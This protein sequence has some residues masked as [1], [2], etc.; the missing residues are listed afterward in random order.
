MKLSLYQGDITDEHVDAIVNAANERL[1]H[2]GGVAA[3]IVQKGGR[4]IQEESTRKIKQHGPLKVGEAAF[5]NEILQRRVNEKRQGERSAT[6]TERD[7]SSRLDFLT[8]DASNVADFEVVVVEPR[9][10]QLLNRIYTNKLQE[11]EENFFVKIDWDENTSQVHIFRRRLPDRESRLDEGFNAFIDLYREF[12]PDKLGRDVVQ[13]PKDV[14]ER[15]LRSIR[16]SMAKDPIIIEREDNKLLVF[17]E[18]SSIRKFAQSLKKKLGIISD[19]SGKRNRLGEDNK[20]L[21]KLSQQD[22]HSLTRRLYHDLNNGVKLSLYQGDI[23]DE[24]VDAIVNAANERLLH[25]GGVAA[26]IVQKGGRQIQEESTRKIKQHGPLKVGE[27]TFTTAGNLACRYVIHTVGPV[28]RKHANE[29]CKHLLHEACMQSLHIASVTLELSSLALTAISS[30]IFGMPKEMC[31]QVMLSAVEAFSSSKEAEF[32]T[33]RDVRIVII[34]EQTL[35]VFQEEFVKRYVSQ[36][37]SPKTVTTRE[38][39][40]NEHSAT[41]LTPQSSVDELLSK[42]D[43]DSPQ[44]RSTLPP[45]EAMMQET[46]ERSGEGEWT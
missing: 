26:A 31:A 27:A 15:L 38:S 44:D 46:I 10:M 25:G 30:G 4:Q 18:K 6:L 36:E 33:L 21:A 34:D 2:G 40:S 45:K 1:L 24:H 42:S 13:L 7:T 32:S 43:G 9:A 17:A 11:I 39:L 16:L 3:A 20:Q 22:Q 12:Y 28:W 41:P 29:E 19:R 23:T 35:S 5:T 8:S 14:D 37:P